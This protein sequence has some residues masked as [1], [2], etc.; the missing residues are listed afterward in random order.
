[1]A[2]PPNRRIIAIVS[3]TL[4][5]GGSTAGFLSTAKASSVAQEP[6]A[7]P[8]THVSVEK[9]SLKEIGSYGWPEMQEAPVLTE[10]DRRALGG[11]LGRVAD[12]AISPDRAALYVL[13]PHFHKVVVFDSGGAFR[14]V[15]LGGRGKGPGE[16][17]RPRSI[18]ADSDTS[19]L[20]LDPGAARVT[21]FKADGSVLATFQIAQSNPLY[22]QAAGG[23]LYLQRYLLSARETVISM[24]PDGTPVDSS[25]KLT[26]RDSEFSDFGEPGRLAMD[27]A[28]R[29]VRLHPTPGV[30]S[31]LHNGSWSSPRGADLFPR[32]KGVIRDVGGVPQRAVFAGARGFAQLRDGT[33]L[34][35]VTSH[36]SSAVQGQVPANRNFVAI[37]DARGRYETT[38]ELPEGLQTSMTAGFSGDD[39]LIATED[40]APRVRRLRLERI[41]SRST[42]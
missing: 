17:V 37:F 9:Y 38:L 15:I 4:L 21:R 22:I 10:R 14:T 33:T 8:G 28:G 29:A 36:S 13:D 6:A 40:P 20:V 2:P 3:I 25:F 42:H 23:L 34:V 11:V 1:M 31:V 16:F 39:I 7:Y 18:T 26:R 41:S 27:A 5:F 32:M 24:M 19:L 12:M 30:W 35:Y